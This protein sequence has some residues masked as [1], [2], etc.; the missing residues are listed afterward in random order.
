MKSCSNPKRLWKY[1]HTIPIFLEKV[2]HSYTNQTNFGPNFELNHRFSQ[3]W[4]KFEPILAKNWLSFEKL[5]EFTYQINIFI[6]FIHIYDFDTHVGSTSPFRSFVQSIYP[7]TMY[8]QL[9]VSNTNKFN[10]V[11]THGR[12]HCKTSK[13]QIYTKYRNLYCK[14][15]MNYVMVKFWQYDLHNIFKIVIDIKNSNRNSH[16]KITKL[17]HA[18]CCLFSIRIKAF[19]HS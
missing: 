9:R 5:T 14:L 10:T 3:N 13:Y 11:V 15:I 4:Q 18:P 1:T 7:A 8:C 2:A 19:N 6:G 17:R 12:T 16:N